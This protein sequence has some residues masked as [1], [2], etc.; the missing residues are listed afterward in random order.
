MALD[1]I[2]KDALTIVSMLSNQEAKKDNPKEETRSV[3]QFL[4]PRK[5]V[6]GVSVQYIKFVKAVS[7][8][9]NCVILN[10]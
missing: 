5:E 7:K 9:N 1:L 10:N 4:Y 6:L 3:V 2:P 8:L